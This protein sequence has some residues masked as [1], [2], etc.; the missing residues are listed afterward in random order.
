MLS[1]IWNKIKKSIIWLKDRIINVL[2]WL[3]IIGIASAAV[4]SGG[5]EV[6]IDVPVQIIN[7]KE[8]SFSYTDDNE[9]EDFII[10][11]TQS[12]YMNIGGSINLY[13]TVTNTSDNAQDVSIVFSFIDG[14]VSKRY[15]DTIF[16]YDGEEIVEE[17]VNAHFE[18]IWTDSSSTDEV[19]FIPE[20][21]IQVEK[22]K[23]I[24]HNI[25]DFNDVQLENDKIKKI[26]NRAKRYKESI[27]NLKSDETKIF[28]AKIVYTDLNEREE[29]F[30][31]AFGSNGS[32]GHLDPWTYEQKF[33]SLNDGDLNTQ[34]NWSGDTEFDVQTTTKYEGAKGIHI[35]VGD[36]DN[37]AISNTSIATS[38]EGSL[39]FAI[40]FDTTANN[41][42]G[43]KLSESSSVKMEV[44]LIDGAIKMIDGS[45]P[46]WQTV[47]GSLSTDVWY[48]INVEWDDSGQPNQYRVR[49][50]ENGGGW[51][52]FTNWYDTRDSSY[53]EIDEIEFVSKDDD[54]SGGYNNYFDTIT[55]TDPT[56]AA[57]RRI[58]IIE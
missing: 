39:Y 41:N 50:D 15:V 56:V 42:M 5:G 51:G 10:R 44:L 35:A 19:I 32:Y 54:G 20:H 25:S 55:P 24:E 28:K 52:S 45:G 16:E 36:D 37:K 43:I 57:E 27:I 23:W 21:T 29:F 58:I 38:S 26:S 17:T 33:N 53:S 14:N 47:D 46:T 49:V 34:D 1:K 9:G 3:G 11:T 40:R 18:N 13:F 8:F 6:P 2:I 4:F 30:I 12:E 22:T 7:G 48:V 31:E